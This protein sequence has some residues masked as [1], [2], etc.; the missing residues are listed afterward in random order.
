MDRRAFLLGTAAMTLALPMVAR[1]ATPYTPDLLAAE[2]AAG[3]AVF[4]SFKA[5]WCATCAAQ[6]RMIGALLSENPDY[7]RVSF[8]DVDWDEWGNS[9]LVRALNVPRHAT[10]V[11]LKGDQELGRKISATGRDDIKELMDL[12]LAAAA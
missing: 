12:A 8:I 11:V 7:A 4:L 6:E 2:L 3:K 9:D 5:S 1:A 10:L